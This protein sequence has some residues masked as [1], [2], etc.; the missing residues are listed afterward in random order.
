MN[1]G[2]LTLLLERM[3]AA[4]DEHEWVEFKHN[5]DEP[6]AIGEY[7][8]ALAN[9]A[10]LDGEPF[11]YL[12]WGIE[13]GTRKVLGTAFKP[14]SAKGAR[15]CLTCG[16]TSTFARSSISVSMRS[17]AAAGRWWCCACRRPWLSR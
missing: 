17:S 7:I 9:A 11:G 4:S 16:C 15:S 12:V 2:E 10:A 3:L 6:N 1:P 13:N 5:N 14:A 8:S